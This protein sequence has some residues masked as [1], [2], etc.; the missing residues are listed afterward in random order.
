[1]MLSNT[2]YHIG[3]EFTSGD[4]E[5]DWVRFEPL[6]EWRFHLSNLFFVVIIGIEIRQSISWSGQ[7]FRNSGLL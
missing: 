1:M 5:V 6:P 2:L 3:L 7:Q 4:V